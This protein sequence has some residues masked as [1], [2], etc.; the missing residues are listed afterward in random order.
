[1]KKKII[2]TAIIGMMVILQS[3]VYGAELTIYGSGGVTVNIT[4]Q[5]VVVC[6]VTANAVCATITIEDDEITILTGDVKSNYNGQGVAGILTTPDGQVYNVLL[7]NATVS[8]GSSAGGYVG[9]NLT[10]QVINP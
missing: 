5:E 8:G 10:V 4:T 9:S 1:M 6:P 3:V 7:S 2:F